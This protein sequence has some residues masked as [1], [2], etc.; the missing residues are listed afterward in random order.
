[1]DKVIGII[2]IQLDKERHLKFS[3]G[4]AIRFKEV[5]G[6]DLRD[7]EVVKQIMTDMGLE[8][9]VAFIWACLKWE[10]RSLALE[11]VGYMLDFTN[12]DRIRHD[13]EEAITI[14]VPDKVASDPP[15][16]RPNG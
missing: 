16:S 1:M 4:A 7:P 14:S 15:A 12:L 8:D 3:I 5:T 2:P 10:D 9:L 11:D 13:L 6:K